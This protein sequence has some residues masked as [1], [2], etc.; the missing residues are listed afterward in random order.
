MI[1]VVGYCRAHFRI[2]G[3]LVFLPV[4][5]GRCLAGLSGDRLAGGSAT[6][7]WRT[8][9]VI[10]GCDWRC[11]RWLALSPTFCCSS[12]RAAETDASVLMVLLSRA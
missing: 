12:H 1:I 4:D 6:P 2:A 5:D 8:V 11:W 7:K 9:A 3:L 10:F